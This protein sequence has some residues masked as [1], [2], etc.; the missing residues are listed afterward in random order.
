M[1][2]PGFFPPLQVEFCFILLIPWFSG[3]HI[4]V[5]N[6]ETSHQPTHQLV[7][8]RTRSLQLGVVKPV[9]LQRFGVV[10]VWRM[11]I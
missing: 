3:A 8:G 11:Y 10:K 9:V 4:G 1:A 6:E 7:A 5:F 2:F